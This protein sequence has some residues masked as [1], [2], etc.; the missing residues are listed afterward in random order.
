GSHSSLP[1]SRAFVG[2][3]L[4]RGETRIAQAER[5]EATPRTAR[6]QGAAPKADHPAAFLTPKLSAL[7]NGF[8]CLF[9]H[10]NWCLSLLS[11][12]GQ[13]SGTSDEPAERS[14]RSG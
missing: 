14:A 8:A 5:V 6:D 3:L 13:F 12:F 9:G 7:P 4:G 1:C 2:G 10:A 11:G